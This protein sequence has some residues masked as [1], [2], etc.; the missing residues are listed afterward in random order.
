MLEF[1]RTMFLDNTFVVRSN[2]DAS[3]LLQML[4]VTCIGNKVLL[5]SGEVLQEGDNLTGAISKSGSPVA[6]LQDLLHG[7]P[8][9]PEG[10]IP[11]LLA[12]PE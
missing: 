9:L 6:Y 12:S 10:A 7:D 5:Q 8:S 4:P 3:K 11:H 1:P 2:R